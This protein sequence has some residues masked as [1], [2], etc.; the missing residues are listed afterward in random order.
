MNI[1]ELHKSTFN[2]MKRFHSLDH[3]MGPIVIINALLS[4]IVTFIPI[5]FSA[6]ILNE[7]IN[8]KYKSAFF[9]SLVMAIIICI[10][11]ILLEYIKKTFKIRSYNLSMKIESM[12]HEKALELDYESVE[13]GSLIK[14]F[15]SAFMAIRYKGSYDTLLNAYASFLQN[16]ISFIF[17]LGL[18]IK[19]CITYKSSNYKWLNILSN[20][21][22]SILFILITIILVS[23]V[24]GKIIKWSQCKISK[25]FEKKLDSE[26]RFAYLGRMIR[27]EDMVKMI[28]SYDGEELVSDTFINVSKSIKNH[29][30]KECMF[31]N[32]EAVSESFT[33]ALI[34]VLSYGIVTLKI[35]SSA[36]SLGSF[37]KYSQAIVKMNESILGMVSDNEDIRDIMLYI[38]KL[39]KFLDLE[40]K[41]ETGSIPIEKRSDYEYKFCFENV[42][43]KYPNS[44]EYVLK[45]VSC[46]LSLKE[47]SALV[48]PNGAGKSTFI[49]LLCR[50]YEPTKGTITLN[51]IDIKKY[52]YNEY[53][54]L[55][56]VVFQ[57]FGLFSFSLGENVASS[58]NYDENKVKACLERSGLKYFK[59]ELKESFNNASLVDALLGERKNEKFS[60]GEKQKIAI[61][62]ALY[63]DAALVILDEPT[64]ALDPL[65][66]YDIY[67]RFD[68]LVKDKTCI[69][70]SHRMS[71]CR[72]CSDIIVLNKGKIVERGNHNTLLN[73]GNLYSKMW[74]AQAKYYAI[75]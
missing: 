18:T 2:V 30:K 40:N 10:T 19:L 39:M 37:L 64:A 73:E 48:G 6:P 68:S 25:L 3:S 42:W 62:R 52:D 20:P 74:N 46:E 38:N 70:I 65:S 23:G 51:G 61:A 54:S 44:K 49:K 14:E 57:D 11:G 26:N 56:S 33:S 31:C 45:D 15:T 72:F 29:Y 7:L 53:L 4:G 9:Y 5:V 24:M 69:Y 12:L 35:L 41:F 22:F 28:Q 67:E 71:S 43:F 1:I 16:V 32:I 66:E 34:T 27:D 60:G 36:I 47:K 58:I 21:V 59:N 63:K 55:F 17:A 8:R 13:D 50:L 75:S